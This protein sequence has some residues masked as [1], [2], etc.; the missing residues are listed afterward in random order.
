V[1]V[2]ACVRACVRPATS[3]HSLWFRGCSARLLYL[4]YPSRLRACGPLGPLRHYTH[5]AKQ[6]QFALPKDKAHSGP[7]PVDVDEAHHAQVR[8][9]RRT[10]ECRLPG[11]ARSRPG[12]P[13]K[14]G[15]IK[16]AQQGRAWSPLAPRRP[17]ALRHRGPWLTSPTTSVATFHFNYV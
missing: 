15:K 2:R 5:I 7:G 4:P 10:L 6:N 1:C 3:A 11:G 9:P 12:K 16:E 13:D 17:K 8:D 14:P